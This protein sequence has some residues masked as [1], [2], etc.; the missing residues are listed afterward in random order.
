MHG[1]SAFGDTTAGDTALVDVALVDAQ[2][3]ETEDVIDSGG[4]AD[5][6]AADDLPD[7]TEPDSGAIA[8]GSDDTVDAAGDATAVLADTLADLGQLS[9]S[10]AVDGDDTANLEVAPVDTAAAAIPMQLQ[11]SIEPGIEKG[12]LLVKLVPATVF[13]A[14]AMSSDA[15]AI[16]VFA[17]PQPTLPQTFAAE[18]P[19]GVW[20]AQA[21]LLGQQGPLAGGAYCVGLQPQGLDT[22]QAPQWPA[23][24]AITLH[25]FNGSPTMG[26]WCQT[27]APAPAFTAGPFLATPSTKFG[28]A[29]HVAAVQDGD[30]MWVGGSQDGLVSFDLPPMPTVPP[31]NLGNWTVHEGAFCNRL[32]KAG[33]TVFCSSRA[34]YLHAFV[35]DPGVAKQTPQQ[36]PMPGVA[37]E[38]LAA[39]AGVLWVAAHQKGLLARSLT[40][41]WA[42]L[43][44]EI[45]PA[46][47]DVWDVAPLGADHLAVADGANGLKVVAMSGPTAGVVVASLPL[48]GRAAF[49]HVGQGPLLV[50]ALGGGL[51]AVDVAN[52]AA[53][54]LIASIAMQEHV[55][56]ATL[57]GDIVLASTGFHVVALEFPKLGQPWRALRAVP[58]F[59][60]AMDIDASGPK[61]VRS[62]EFTGVRQFTV[63]S[64]AMPPGPVLL[65][66]PNVAA[67]VVKVGGSIQTSIRVHN[68]GS[69]NLQISAIAFDEVP[70]TKNGTVKLPGS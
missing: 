21:L 2:T 70:P 23:V 65:T 17:G 67:Q 24:V 11:V 37:T 55:F 56:S 41:P 33:D 16:S 29:H 61:L 31:G 52:P 32:L 48:A 42:E 39:R 43:L 35:I 13:F 36:I 64:S 63:D 50:S 1:D 20:V 69:K 38:G 9:D 19:P 7:D 22:A 68:A 49:L 28:G 30:R 46:L 12:I 59:G 4:D 25:K 15:D 14:G 5:A 54:T 51:H 34:G 8:D 26:A 47:V 57:L 44:V 40:A 58:S 6:A 27:T 62:A 60:Y 3:A 66:H 18:A 10:K 53:P 45:T